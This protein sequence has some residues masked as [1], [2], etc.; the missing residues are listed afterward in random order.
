[1]CASCPVC[2]TWSQQ[3]EPRGDK[4][5]LQ[6]ALEQNI[7]SSTGTSVRKRPLTNPLPVN[8]GAGLRD[9]TYLSRPMSPHAPS[10][11]PGC[12][13][14]ALTCLVGEAQGT[15]GAHGCFGCGPEFG[16]TESGSA[17]NGCEGGVARRRLVLR[18]RGRQG[19]SGQPAWT[20]Y[21]PGGR[22]P[23]LRGQGCDGAGRSR[24]PGSC[25]LR[26]RDSG[27]NSSVLGTVLTVS[28]VV[29]PPL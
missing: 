2:G 26:N 16:W 9:P 24:T 8:V 27:N 11:S 14:T 13:Q 21:C 19:A 25:S 15:A 17:E 7:R 28:D 20:P 1:M 5:K 12:L 4:T 22:R 10:G 18:Y 3:L 6:V 29:H 23:W